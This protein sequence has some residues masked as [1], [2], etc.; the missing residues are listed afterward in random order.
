[1]F[2]ITNPPKEFAYTSKNFSLLLKLKSLNNL[3]PALS[4]NA[5]NFKLNDCRVLFIF[6]A[7]AKYRDPS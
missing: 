6:K 7:C 5:F 3:D 4:S 2:I 1:M